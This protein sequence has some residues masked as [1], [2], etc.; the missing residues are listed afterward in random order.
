[1]PKIS[2]IIPVYNTEKYLSE[3]L[4]SV[5][6][7]TFT[8]IEVICVNDGSSDNSAKIL[9]QY[10]AR[11]KRIHIINQKNSG[12]VT[13]RNNGIKNAQSDLIFPLDGDDFIEPTTLEK[14]YKSMMSGAGDIITCRVELCGEQRGEM[15]LPRPTKFNMA[16]KN[17]LVNAALFK[18]SD[19]IAC[20]GYSNEFDTALEDY[21]L[22][23]N[24]VFNH[25]KKIYRI[26]E[27]LFYYRIKQK[28]ESRNMQ[29]SLF[30]KQLIKQL[31][32]KYSAMRLY[33]MPY[34]IGMNFVKFGHFFFRIKKNCIYIF[35]I[36]VYRIRKY[37]T[38][39]SVGA[40]CFVP[41]TLTVLKLRDFSGPF[42]WMY[43]SDVITRLKCI[44][45]EF[46]HYFD[47]SDFE[48]VDINPDNNKAVYKNNRTGI[49]YNHD[50]EPGDFA[51]TFPPIAEKY[52]RRTTRM[53]DHLNNDKRVLLVFSELGQT[54]NK[55]K[56]IKIIDKIN[57]KFNAKIDF[58]YINHNP[59]MRPGIYTK[60]KRISKNVIYCEYYYKTYPTETDAASRILLKVITKIAK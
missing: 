45:D 48:Y 34:K 44:Y 58:L 13:A 8:D 30:H 35:K 12:V 21:D 46:N 43:G 16:R 3:C 18:K 24:M 32:N 37:D 57:A 50:F 54:G 39:I 6:K 33:L 27:K 20:G 42:D 7:Q 1:M 47:Y 41:S 55:N 38:V 17:C 26:P 52:A 14:M 9:E 49:Y 60:P 59:D 15:S 23:L 53:L 10:A 31:Y 25:N 51:V 36:P 2:V 5:L 28:S 11:D 56:I 29:T 19:F 22:W 40:A 4:D